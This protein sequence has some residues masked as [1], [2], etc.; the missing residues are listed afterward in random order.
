MVVQPPSFAW[1]RSTLRWAPINGNPSSPC[2][3]DGACVAQQGGRV[4]RPCRWGADAAARLRPVGMFGAW[5]GRRWDHLAWFPAS[6]GR[7]PA[8]RRAASIRQKSS[9]V[10]A[11]GNGSAGSGSPRNRHSGPQPSATS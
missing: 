5:M 4:G 2:K 9:V 11:R 6:A 10:L 3:P 1:P 7:E 8:S